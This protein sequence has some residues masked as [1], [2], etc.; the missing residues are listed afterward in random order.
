MYQTCKPS[1]CPRQNASPGATRRLTWHKIGGFRWLKQPQ[2]SGRLKVSSIK[3]LPENFEVSKRIISK[4]SLID[5][6]FWNATGLSTKIC[7]RSTK[8]TSFGQC[9]AVQEYDPTTKRLTLVRNTELEFLDAPGFIPVG[10]GRRFSKDM[11]KFL[12]APWSFFLYFLK[13]CFFEKFGQ[14]SWNS[15]KE[16][17]FWSVKQ[18]HADLWCVSGFFF[19]E[20]LAKTTFATSKEQQTL[21]CMCRIF[22]EKASVTCLFPTS[23]VHNLA[24]GHEFFNPGQHVDRQQ[25]GYDLVFRL[26]KAMWACCLESEILFIFEAWQHL[27]I[28][29]MTSWYLRIL[30]FFANFLVTVVERESADGGGNCNLARWNMSDFAHLFCQCWLIRYGERPIVSMVWTFKKLSGS[31]QKWFVQIFLFWNGGFLP[32]LIGTAAIVREVV[33]PGD[34]DELLF[35]A[36]SISC[37]SRGFFHR[38][39]FVGPGMKGQSCR[40]LSRWCAQQ[41]TEYL[42][43]FQ[44]DSDTW[45]ML[46]FP[47]LKSNMNYIRYQI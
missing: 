42:H 40:I 11:R 22:G 7:L 45:V 9:P 47:Y 5:L 43:C 20:L 27:R 14:C 19:F 33:Y 32:F 12:S 16:V 23:R 46:F 36:P 38:F 15:I 2:K 26:G 21:L 25:V 30:A 4:K 10:F 37:F 13:T 31:Q 6:F 3:H 8:I 39:S 28:H 41:P 17:A 18:S 34:F 29:S 35:G 24:V 1:I 44:G